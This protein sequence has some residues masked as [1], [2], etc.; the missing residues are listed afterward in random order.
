MSLSVEV[1]LA[2]GSFTLDVRLEIDRGLTAL[3]GPSGAGKTTI[4]NVVAGL[5]R[6]DRCLVR[7]DDEVLADTRAGIWLRPHDRQIGYVFQDPRLF[8]HMSVER[9]LLYGARRRIRADTPPAL[10]EVVALLNL[11]QLLARYPARLSGGEKQRVALGRALMSNPRVLLLDEP[12]AS[13]DQAHRAE[14]LP[15]LDAFRSSSRLP[16]IYVTHALDEVENRADRIVEIVGGRLK[17]S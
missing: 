4:L 5:V 3:V 2:V 9:N 13:V 8:P 7:L 17:R 11:G 12:L 14:I 10:T 6:P 1:V 15:Y 16:T